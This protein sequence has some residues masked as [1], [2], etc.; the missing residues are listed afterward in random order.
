M[1]T[2]SLDLTRG[3]RCE[4]F[5][6][7]SSGETVHAY[8]LTNANG[9]ALRFLTLGG[10]IASL[11]VPDR[12]GALDDVV[13]GYDTLDAYE[14]DPRYLGT[15]VGRYAN[16][17]A[18]GRFTLDGTEHVVD[19]ND[20]PNHLHGGPGGFHTAVWA[21]EPFADERGVGAVLRHV[22]P[23][24]DEGYPGALAAHV[25]YT[26]TQDDALV[27]E[28]HATTTRATP[29]NLTQHAYFN[30]AG[31]GAGDVCEHLLTLSASRYTPVDALLIPTGEL[32]AVQDTPFDFRTPT[33][34]G[35][36]IDDADPQ[37]AHAGGYD[38]NF[39]IDGDA[40][41]L[42]FA[43]RVH[44]PRSGRA[45]D[46]FTTEPG[47]HFYSGNALAEGPPGKGGVRYGARSGLALET[48]HFPDSPNQPHF[49]STILRPGDTYTSRTVFRFSSTG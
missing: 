37:L 23:D 12:D 29:V 47:V 46:V 20:G 35:A 3:V 5:G 26:L 13:L 6:V 27:V 8:T 42:R 36:R 17:I 2:T 4:P 40:P 11:H 19:A 43:A 16:R 49:P 14:A 30:L 18:G 38:H 48:Q 31:H 25:R 22:S 21:T 33:A 7:T 28:Y 39:V 24:G 10:I 15:L 34:I 41:G 44:E 1:S 32:R 45:L 9:V